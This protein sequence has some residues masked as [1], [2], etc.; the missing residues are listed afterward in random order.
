MTVSGGREI[1]NDMVASC[2]RQ[3]DP[4]LGNLHVGSCPVKGLDLSLAQE[5]AASFPAPA[6]PSLAL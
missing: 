2:R 4:N 1:I 5:V 3:A 6:L